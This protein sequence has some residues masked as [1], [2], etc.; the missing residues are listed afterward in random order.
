MRPR[1]SLILTFAAM[2]CWFA[3]NLYGQ[4]D[5]LKFSAVC[6]SGQTLYYKITS[7]KPYTVDVVYELYDPKK[8]YIDNNSQYY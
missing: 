7:T 6:E 4:T 5:E 1:I 8:R 2:L 3:P